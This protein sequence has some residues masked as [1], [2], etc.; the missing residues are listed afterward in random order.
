MLQGI[1]Y[2]E[3]F[4]NLVH[5]SV[6]YLLK[7][8]WSLIG[9]ETTRFQ[10]NLLPSNGICDAVYID[11]KNSVDRN[12]IIFN[13]S[14]VKSSSVIILL[15]S[16]TPTSLNEIKTSIEIM[17]LILYTNEDPLRRELRIIQAIFLL[18]CLFLLT[19]FYI[20][21]K[22]LAFVYLGN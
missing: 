19:Y 20:A 21:M 9:K 15:L 7:S 2:N 5:S 1:I 17:N 10:L 14:Y 18:Q 6:L 8:V 3:I 22:L 16:N 13:I 12:L 11:K 4:L